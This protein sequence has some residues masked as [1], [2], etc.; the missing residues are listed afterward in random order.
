MP[1]T[2][3]EKFESRHQNKDATEL[4]YIIKGVEE[5]DDDDAAALA[6]LNATSPTEY[7]GKVRDDSEVEPLGPELWLGTARYKPYELSYVPPDS[8]GFVRISLSTVGGSG[9]R[10]F[11]FETVQSLG[12]NKVDH[13]GAINVNAD[14]VAEGVQIPMPAFHFTVKKVFYAS[15]LPDVRDL[16]IVRTNTRPFCVVDSRTGYRLDFEAGECLFLGV[17]MPEARADGCVELTYLFEASPNEENQ[18]WRGIAGINKKGWEYTWFEDQQLPDGTKGTS[19][20]AKAAYTERVHYQ[21]D[22]AVLGI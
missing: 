17:E 1:I 13:K 5:G 20:T 22:F 7:N 10:R 15:D 8:P 9:L 2:V 11:S 18:T 14:G 12:T 21:G 3:E 19:T 6:A 4:I 16:Y